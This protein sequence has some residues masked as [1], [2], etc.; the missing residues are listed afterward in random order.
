MYSSKLKTCSKR[1]GFTLIELLMVI[2]VLAVL[3]SLALV[4]VRGAE[5]DA[6]ESATQ[7]RIG[8]IRTLML[9]RF[10]DY[11]FRKSPVRLTSY[12]NPQNSRLNAKILRQRII[13][14]IINVELPRGAADLAMY[15][16]Q[17]F[18]D[19]AMLPSSNGFFASASDRDRLLADLTAR[20]PALYTRMRSAAAS[21]SVDTT[22]E[23]LYLALALTDFDG[24][25]GTELLGRAEGDGDNDGQPDIVDAWDESMNFGINFRPH[26][27]GPSVD[28]RAAIA[29]DEEDLALQH[30]SHALTSSRLH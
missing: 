24:V 5:Q 28:L 3:A 29:S 26:D 6:K 22:S 1:T 17:A 25:P 15:P 21:S 14:D 16:S 12:V 10:E 18:R 23:Y 9:Q 4:A 8:Q 11:E 27:G 7:S 20:P 30:T 13:A 19:W 2:S